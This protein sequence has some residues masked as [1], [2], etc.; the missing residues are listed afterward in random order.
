M[1]LSKTE[2][3]WLI[4]VLVFYTLYNLP[5]VPAYNQ[6][7]PALLHGLLTLI[8]LWAAI[9][10]GLFRVFREKPLRTQQAVQE[11]PY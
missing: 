7:I 6:T 11:E 3:R 1:K 8:P 2:K 9:Y 4:S 5:F 10:I